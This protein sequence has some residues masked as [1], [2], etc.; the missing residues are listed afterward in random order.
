MSD[1]PQP[2]AGQGPLDPAPARGPQSMHMNAPRPG[3]PMPP[4]G[5]MPPGMYP[6]FPMMPPP[7]PSGGGG[8]GFIK[9]IF[10]TLAVVVFVISLLL[11]VVLLLGSA[12][13]GVGATAAGTTTKSLKSGGDSNQKVAVVRFEGVIM[14]D[15]AEKFI[16]LLDKVEGDNSVKALVIQIDSPGGAVTPSDE[17]YNRILNLKT[18]RKIP[19]VVSM[20]SLAASGGYYMACAADEIVAQRTTLT[21]SIGVYFGLMDLTGMADKI[22]YK[23]RTIVADGGTYKV[24]GSMWKPMNED[25]E[26]YFKSLVNDSLGHFKGVVES[27]RKGKLKGDVSS[28]ANGK[29]FSGQQALDL[30]LVDQLGYLDTAV[31]AAAKRAGLSNPMPVKFER[32]KTFWDALGGNAKA[33]TPGV[34]ASIG[35]AT[36]R[37]DPKLVYELTQPRLMVLWPSR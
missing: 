35:G 31:S 2:P 36:I 33:T 6:P 34:E 32:E 16:E 12:F 9:A 11:N 15:S 22:G 21:G 29:I 19:V 23:D 28:V 26:K 17:I 10:L 1:T 14:T 3:M 7:R 30:G 13:S 24:S 5:G 37:I 27:G 8:W 25:E 18:A 20:D 4:P